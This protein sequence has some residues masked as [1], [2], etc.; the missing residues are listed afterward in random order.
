MMPRKIGIF[1]PNWIGDVAMATP[2]LRAIHRKFGGTAE[3]VAIQ[4]PYVAAVLEGNPWISRSISY[5]PKTWFTEQGYWPLLQSLWREKFDSLVLFPNSLVSGALAWLAGAPQRAGFA[6]DWRGWLL[7]DP[8]APSAEPRPLVDE[9]LEI[10]YRLGCPEESKRL[11]LHTTPADEAAADYYWGELEL[12]ANGGEVVLLNGGGG[13][14]GKASAKAWPV[15]NFAALARKIVDESAAHV[16][17]NCGPKEREQAAAIVSLADHPRVVSLAPLRPEELTLGLTKAS[18][19]RSRL[20]VT[21]DSG[22]RHI[23][24]AFDKPVVTLFGPTDPRD[25]ET[26]HPR[27]IHLYDKFECAPCWEQHCPLGHHACMRGLSVERVYAAV[28]AVMTRWERTP[29]LDS[30]AVMPTRSAA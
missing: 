11:E 24:T 20:V 18:I 9:Y 2:A 1:L 4:R 30:F 14:G 21:T 8:I 7:S 6:R 22:P 15:E 12:P 5:D 19:R 26:Y 3:L 17:V 27:A 16:L 10:A 23:A 25:T 29:I 28:A 13:W